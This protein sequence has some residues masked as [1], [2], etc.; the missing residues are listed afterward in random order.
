MRVEKVKELENYIDELKTIK[1]ELADRKAKFLGIETYDCFLN[2]GRV[3]PRERIIKGNGKGDACIILP[4][5]ED[6][7]VL[8]V[9]QPRVFTECGVSVELP[10][11][12]VDSEE[13]YEDAAKRELFEETGYVTKKMIHLGSFYQDQ[14]CMSAFNKCFL[15]YDCK[16]VGKQHLDGDEI[17]KYF[18]CSVEDM[19]ELVEKGLICDVNSQFTI[20]KAKS[21]ILK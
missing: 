8:L 18:E 15:A 2:N 1:L 9:V 6:G 5:T 4:V 21:Y 7:N 14:G 10:A 17:I 20:E 11:G 12:Y 13:E 16:K 19:F 3:I